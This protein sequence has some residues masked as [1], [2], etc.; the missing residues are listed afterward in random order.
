M[1]NNAQPNSYLGA[2]IGVLVVLGTLLFYLTA[3]E[4]GGAKKVVGDDDLPPITSPSTP[5]R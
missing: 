1:A 3:G 4:L 5:P 2:A